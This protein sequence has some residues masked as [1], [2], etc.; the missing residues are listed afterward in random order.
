MTC[1]RAAGLGTASDASSASSASGG[2]AVSRFHQPGHD[3]G[4]D[5]CGVAG[6]AARRDDIGLA[7]AGPFDLRVPPR[8]V[9]ADRAD[10]D[11][12]V[13][14]AQKRGHRGPPT[15][16]DPDAHQHPGPVDDMVDPA[17]HL[18]RRPVIGVGDPRVGVEPGPIVEVRALGRA[19]VEEAFAHPVGRG[20]AVDLPDARRQAAPAVE[21]AGDG[22]GVAEGDRLA[23]AGDEGDPLVAVQRGVGG[24]LVGLALDV[25][26]D[27]ARAGRGSRPRRRRA[28]RN[29]ARPASVWRRSRLASAGLAAR[30][31]G[32]RS[33]ACAQAD[34]ARH[35]PSTPIAA[36]SAAGEPGARRG[37]C[38]GGIVSIRAGPPSAFLGNA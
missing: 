25:P 37:V 28:S 35:T 30:G 22:L 26:D 3:G 18:G 17:E 8:A 23:R 11:D 6:Q 31:F 14:A 1:G 20:E 34:P 38:M 9:P 36:A 12:V 21:L 15:V 10:R 27:D 16:V 4:G 7:P 19:D 13:R 24:V 33:A 29:P 5:G 2:H 32:R